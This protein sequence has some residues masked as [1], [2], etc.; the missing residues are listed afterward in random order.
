MFLSFFNAKY[1]VRRPK[2]SKIFCS[3]LTLLGM[4]IGM[5]TLYLL[6]SL[7]SKILMLY[8]VIKTGLHSEMV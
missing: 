1:M 6:A 4:L 3:S 7:K 2:R 5:L 8:V